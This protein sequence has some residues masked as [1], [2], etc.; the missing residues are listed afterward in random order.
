MVLSGLDMDIVGTYVYTHTH[1]HTHTLHSQHPWL[2]V[3]DDGA[4]KM[5]YLRTQHYLDSGNF[6]GENM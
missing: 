5:N 4:N 2:S 1:T 6:I 3:Q